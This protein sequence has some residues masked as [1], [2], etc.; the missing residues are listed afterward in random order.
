MPK[1]DENQVECLVY[2]FKDGLLSKIAHDL[3]IK[4]AGAQVDLQ[5]AAVRAEFDAS[6][7]RVLTPMKDGQDNPAAL[8]ESDKAKIAEQIVDDV[9]HAK[10]YPKALFVSRSMTPRA[11]GG[12]DI[13]GDLTLH[14]VTK[15]LNVRSELRGG[16]QVASIEIHQPDFGI[17]PYKAMMGT[18]KIKPS[19]R[20]VLSVPQS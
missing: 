14:G 9:L 8:S 12:Y 6:S 7:L 1:Y 13:S 4:V 3:K 18:L 15:P 20:V 16:R 19:V 11:D 2:T 5:P 17:T 10:R